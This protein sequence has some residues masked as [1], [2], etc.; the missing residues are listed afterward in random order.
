MTAAEIQRQLA[1]LE[2]HQFFYHVGVFVLGAITLSQGHL[3]GLGKRH[4]KWTVEVHTGKSEFRIESGR[5]ILKALDVALDRLH[6]TEGSPDAVL[7]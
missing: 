2:D 7:S 4:G 6:R 5:S 1:D 3:I